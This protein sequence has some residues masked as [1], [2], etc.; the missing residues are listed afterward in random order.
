[1]IGWLGPSEKYHNIIKIDVWVVRHVNLTFVLPFV[2]DLHLQC[3][4]VCRKFANW[5]VFARKRS[6]LAK[7]YFTTFVFYTFRSSATR[8]V[9]WKVSFIRNNATGSRASLLHVLWIRVFKTGYCTCSSCKEQEI[10]WMSG[11]HEALSNA[12]GN[13]RIL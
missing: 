8:E 3:G 10:L 7:A 9:S 4:S 11:L 12:S 6:T 13:L 5:S 2:P 1:M